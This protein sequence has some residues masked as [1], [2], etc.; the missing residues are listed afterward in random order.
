MVQIEIS[1]VSQAGHTYTISSKSFESAYER[2]GQIERCIEG[3]RK[4]VQLKED[5]EEEE[6]ER[7]NS[8]R[9]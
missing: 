1:I 8:L 7:A 6:L 4:Q 5:M 9:N 2:M 3:L